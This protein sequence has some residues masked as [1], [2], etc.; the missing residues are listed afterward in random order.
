MRESHSTLSASR[1][2]SGDPKRNAD[3][4]IRCN[5]S[6]LPK[7]RRCTPA[8]AATSPLNPELTTLWPGSKTGLWVTLTMSRSAATGTNTV[9]EF[10][11]LTHH[12]DNS[13]P[14]QTGRHQFHNL[15]WPDVG[16][17]NCLAQRPPRRSH[18]ALSPP[19]PDRRGFHGLSHHPQ[20]IMA[21]TGARRHRRVSL[22]F[23]RCHLSP[24][25][26]GGNIW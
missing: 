14:G 3:T 12:L 1:L 11:D 7:L 2:G 13:S 17:R 25:H 20:S 26:L 18:R 19:P 8:P 6:V 22:Q 15:R 24:R 5:R 21:F 10:F 4:P 23:P 9:G 16:G